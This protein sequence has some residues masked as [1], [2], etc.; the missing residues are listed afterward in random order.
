MSKTCRW[1]P[2]GEH[3]VLN[4]MWLASSG[5][6][7]PETA[8]ASGYQHPTMGDVISDRIL[9]RTIQLDKPHVFF[10]LFFFCLLGSPRWHGSTAL[11]QSQGQQKHLLQS[12]QCV[13]SCDQQKC[14]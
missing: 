1:G 13:L 10:F 2:G 4:T 12:L 11:Q 7:R 3:A 6:E 14:I 9:P 5:K 8:L